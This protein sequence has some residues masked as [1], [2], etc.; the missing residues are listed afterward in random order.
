MC[1]ETVA[2]EHDD[3]VVLMSID[4]GAGEA[5]SDCNAKE[6][7]TLSIANYGALPL[8]IQPGTK[9][10]S[11]NNFERDMKQYLKKTHGIL[12]LSWIVS[13]KNKD[14]VHSHVELGGDG[15]FCI[16]IAKSGCVVFASQMNGQ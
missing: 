1:K 7:E 5:S 15:L 13:R 4:D 14:T 11:Q 12:S 9:F 2:Q 10:Y 6:T 8:P 3:D 16:Y